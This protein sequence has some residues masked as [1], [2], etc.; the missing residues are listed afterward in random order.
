M[1]RFAS[2]EIKMNFLSV[3]FTN[4]F[5]AALATDSLNKYFKNVYLRCGTVLVIKLTFN[6]DDQET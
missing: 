1:D 4:S 5:L 2:K 6:G 3:L